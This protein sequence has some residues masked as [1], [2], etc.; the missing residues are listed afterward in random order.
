MTI[1]KKREEKA[2]VVDTME[3][4]SGSVATRTQI[5][6]VARAFKTLARHVLHHSEDAVAEACLLS[7]IA[8][9]PPEGP[10]L[11]TVWK[12]LYAALLTPEHQSNSA[13]PIPAQSSSRNISFLHHILLPLHPLCTM[14]CNSFCN[15]LPLLT[16]CIF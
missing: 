12:E 2:Q 16:V 4:S 13:L 3:R 8:Y 11:F 7:F 15:I 10:D 6:G 1:H 14:L 5:V 9:E